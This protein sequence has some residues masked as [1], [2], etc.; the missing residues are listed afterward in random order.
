MGR[1]L[2][3]IAILIKR[4]GVQLSGQDIIVNVAGGFKSTEPAVDLGIALA[5]TSS[6]SNTPLPYGMAALGEIGLGGEL[7][8]TSHLSRRLTELRHMGFDTCLCPET[9][10]QPLDLWLLI[11][12]QVFQSSLII[13]LLY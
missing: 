11:P 3:V 7:R 8:S 12:Q 2:M 1:L 10:I 4:A 9:V 13:L 6:L 5:L